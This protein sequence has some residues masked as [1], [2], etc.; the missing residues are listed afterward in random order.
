MESNGRHNLYVGISR[1]GGI[2]LNRK[3]KERE[4]PALSAPKKFSEV[5]KGGVEF[6]HALDIFDVKGDL[7]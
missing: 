6:A 2:P 3:I 4:N 7:I 5:R 1:L